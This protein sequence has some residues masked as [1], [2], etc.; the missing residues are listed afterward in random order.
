[1]PSQSYQNNTIHLLR[2]VEQQE[3]SMNLFLFLTLV[4]P[5][6]EAAEA[7]VTSTQSVGS[8]LGVRLHHDLDHNGPI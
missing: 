8:R 2:C 5:H 7:E 4:V 1:M 6:P 3:C